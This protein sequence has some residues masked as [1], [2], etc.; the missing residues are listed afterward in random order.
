MVEFVGLRTLFA[1][2]KRWL[3]RLKSVFQASSA[4]EPVQIE[5][6]HPQQQSLFF[7]RLPIEVREI[8][9]YYVFGPSLIRTVDMGY[10]L[11]HVRCSMWQI[12]EV[13]DRHRHG[14]EGL[15][16]WPILDKSKDRDD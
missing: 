14:N 9:Y 3:S 15:E 8:I 10:R 6:P 12:G 13:W 2:Q 7:N 4:R 11:V 16:C 1:D 5:K